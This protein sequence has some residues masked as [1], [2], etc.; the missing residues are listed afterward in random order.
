MKTDANSPTPET[1]PM[2]IMPVTISQSTAQ[3]PAAPPTTMLFCCLPSALAA[4]DKN[5]NTATAPRLAQYQTGAGFHPGRP[6]FSR[7][8]VLSHY[9][10]SPVTGSTVSLLP[11]SSPISSDVRCPASAR[12]CVRFHLSSAGF[13]RSTC[14]AFSLP[15]PSFSPLYENH[16]P[17]FSTMPALTPRSISSPD[18]GNP[19]TVHNVKIYGLKRR[20]HLVLDNLTRVWLPITSSLSLIAPTRR[21]SIRID[22]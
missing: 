11:S 1:V 5:K 4:R 14:L 13:S 21:I 19:L 8:N 22:A 15:C 9:D 6:F 16:A 20:S 7:C 2:A 17:A 12:I 3:Q 10:T 18:L